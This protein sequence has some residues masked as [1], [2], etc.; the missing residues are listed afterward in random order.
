M[1]ES[2]SFLA[3]VK[4]QMAKNGLNDGNFNV[5][6]TMNSSLNVSGNTTLSGNVLICNS[7]TDSLGFFSNTGNSQITLTSGSTVELVLNALGSYGLINLIS[8]D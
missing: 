2:S 3:L 7:N 4:S 1:S 8:S 6:V 5:A